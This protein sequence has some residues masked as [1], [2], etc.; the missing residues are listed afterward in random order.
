MASTMAQNIKNIYVF[1]FKLREKLLQQTNANIHSK[2]LM[3]KMFTN[4]KKT[5][6]IF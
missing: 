5:K 6:N 4:V 2:L 1:M 3:A